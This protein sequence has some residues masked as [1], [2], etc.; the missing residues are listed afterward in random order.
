MIIIRPRGVSL[1]SC[2]FLPLGIRAYWFDGYG[3]E[4][5]VPELLNVSNIY[6]VQIANVGSPSIV[7]PPPL[8]SSP[9][10]LAFEVS[11]F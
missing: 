11:F 6:G 10:I 5:A 4:T 9:F 7:R 2:V 8:P 3:I 1:V